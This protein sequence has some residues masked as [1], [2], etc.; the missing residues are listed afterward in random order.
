MVGAAKPEEEAKR[1]T[2]GFQRSYSC[3]LFYEFVQAR[4]NMI[5]KRIKC[6]I[7]VEHFN[8]LTQYALA[9]LLTVNFSF[10]SAFSTGWQH[11]FNNRSVNAR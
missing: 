3:F 8:I 5:G 1:M 7:H 6:E 9:A 4:K 2:K 10:T 11:G